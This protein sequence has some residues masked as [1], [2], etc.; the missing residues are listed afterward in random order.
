[1]SDPSQDKEIVDRHTHIWYT[2]IP[3]NQDNSND[4]TTKH[5]TESNTT[6]AAS[7]VLQSFLVRPVL[8]SGAVCFSIAFL[9][10]MWH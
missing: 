8:I 7:M 1:V 6:A 2:T 4:S 5:K 10:L 9:P 3:F